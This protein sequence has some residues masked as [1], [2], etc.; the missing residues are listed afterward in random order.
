MSST[1]EIYII[2][3]VIVGPAQNPALCS[4]LSYAKKQT[5]PISAKEALPSKFFLFLQ[6]CLVLPLCAL[7][8]VLASTAASPTI[9]INL[10][11]LLFWFLL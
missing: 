3:F 1:R 11:C 5:N 9:F 7:V 2:D 4:V 10:P 8:D 6:T